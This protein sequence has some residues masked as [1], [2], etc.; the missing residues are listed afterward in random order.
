MRT[1]TDE[2]ASR[3]DVLS[4]KHPP[5]PSIDRRQGQ[6]IPRSRLNW[7]PQQ[8]AGELAAPGLPASAHG[9]DAVRA[10][11]ASRRR[12]RVHI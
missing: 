5:A 7:R 4:P 2:P 9:W 8:P 10:P 3:D 6:H 12:A 11:A 1:K